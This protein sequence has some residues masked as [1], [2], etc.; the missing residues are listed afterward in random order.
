MNRRAITLSFLGA[1]ALCVLVLG[2]FVTLVQHPPAW[3]LWCV[4]LVAAYLVS[5]YQRRTGPGY[6]IPAWCDFSGIRVSA[7]MPTSFSGEADCPLRLEPLLA[8]ATPTLVYRRY[9]TAEEWTRQTFVAEGEGMLARIPHQPPAGKI[10]YHIELG[11]GP[12]R[13]TLPKRDNVIVR[14]R[15]SV[16]AATLLPHVLLVLLGMVLSIRTGLETWYDG[17]RQLSF[18]VVTLVALVGGGMVFGPLVQKAAFGKYWTGI[19]FGHDLTDNKMLIAILAWALALATSLGGW[20]G[21]PSMRL[22]ASGLTLLAFLI[23]HSLFG[24]ELRYDE[25]PAR[26]ASDVA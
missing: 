23:P 5:R 14:Y 11:E 3:L 4:T 10:E 7:K 13:R 19:P 6:D 2:L 25:V 18:M 20:E 12:A 1:C 26:E 24:S 21:A 22:A 16:P 8:E 17:P 9:P 15:G